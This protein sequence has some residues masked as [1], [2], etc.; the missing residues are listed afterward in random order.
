VTAS[1]CAAAPP[2]QLTGVCMLAR[3]AHGLPE[4][5]YVL[6]AYPVASAQG[7]GQQRQPGE[8]GP[9][10]QQRQR[11]PGLQV[12]SG[13]ALYHLGQPDIS[14]AYTAR[15]PSVFCETVLRW[16]DH[17]THHPTEQRMIRPLDALVSHT[18]SASYIVAR[19]CTC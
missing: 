14:A 13:R 15:D 12:R 7:P 11:P 1:S 16:P 5:I 19:C 4:I 17:Y 3:G 2:L 18:S 8:P 10:W 9:Q 6:N